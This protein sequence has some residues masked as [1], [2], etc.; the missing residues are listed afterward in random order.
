MKDEME[1]LLFA[2]IGGAAEGAIAARIAEFGGLLTRQ[3]AVRLLCKERGI[4]V[5]RRVSLSGARGQK[6]HFSFSARVGRVFP[7]QKFPNSRDSSLRMHISDSSGQSTLV[8]WNEQCRLEKEIFAG[9]EIE[10]AGAYF[11][12][13]EIFI[14]K[15][16]SVKKTGGA[17]AESLDGLREGACS[18]QGIVKGAEGERSFRRNGEE[19]RMFSFTICQGETCARAVAWQGN[20][21]QFEIPSEGD[22]VL[23]ENAFFRAGEVHLSAKSRLVIISSSQEKEGVVERIAVEGGNAVFRIGGGEFSLPLASALP[24]LQI[25]SLPPG[26]LSGTALSIKAG[27]LAGKTVRYASKGK[28]LLRLSL[29][30]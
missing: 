10:C 12:A 3:A 8:L 2:K 22:T 17:Q 23:L 6:G 25:R 18:V 7:V 13:G 21:A 26:V 1:G 5:E 4:A 16:G 14:A 9:D 27:E 30:G 28:T 11:R 29:E 19:R 20:G 24:L 15:S